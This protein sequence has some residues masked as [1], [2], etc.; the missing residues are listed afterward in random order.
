LVVSGASIFA[1][2]MTGLVDALVATEIG[3][4]VAAIVTGCA[5]AAMGLAKRKNITP[6]KA[7]PVHVPIVTLVVL[8][9]VFCGLR[10]L[11]FWRFYLGGFGYLILVIL[12]FGLY[13]IWVIFDSKTGRNTRIPLWIYTAVILVTLLLDT[14]TTLLLVLVPTVIGY[15]ICRLVGRILWRAVTFPFWMYLVVLL[16]VFLFAY[17]TFGI[18]WGG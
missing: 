17:R 18:F 12:L 13:G 15:G 1:F 7:R 3:I 6:E 11:I 8:L 16:P 14:Y 9:V 5:Y 2:P 4:G 10:F